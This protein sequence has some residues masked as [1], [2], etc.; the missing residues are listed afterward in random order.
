MCPL[1][2]IHA[3]IYISVKCIIF[4]KAQFCT[5]VKDIYKAISQSGHTA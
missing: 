5:S 4:K 2:F 3:V 1:S